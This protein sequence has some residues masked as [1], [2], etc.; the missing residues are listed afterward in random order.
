MLENYNFQYILLGNFQTDKLEDRFG[1]QSQMT[2]A[3]HNVSA[4]QLLQSENKLKIVKLLS[5]ASSESGIL[6]KTHT[7]HSSLEGVECSC[8]DY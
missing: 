3:N 8:V 4:V 5:L 6:R 7:N 2:R 1:Q